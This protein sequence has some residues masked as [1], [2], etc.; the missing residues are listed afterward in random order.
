MDLIFKLCIANKSIQIDFQL[1]ALTSLR[2]WVQFFSNFFYLALALSPYVYRKCFQQFYKPLFAKTGFCYILSPSLQP[3]F[4]VKSV[5]MTTPIVS[6][7]Q[8]DDYFS[9]LKHRHFLFATRWFSPK[10]R[11]FSSASQKC[12]LCLKFLCLAFK[13]KYCSSINHEL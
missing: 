13:N 3:S 8:G 9:I 10:H 7:N 12:H 6:E 1:K 4:K 5:S 2:L 11:V